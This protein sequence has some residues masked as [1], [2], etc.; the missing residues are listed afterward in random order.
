MDTTVTLDEARMLLGQ[1][2]MLIFVLE[3]ENAR[4]AA[5]TLELDARVDTLLKEKDAT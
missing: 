4:L 2:D 5:R 1:R 3:R